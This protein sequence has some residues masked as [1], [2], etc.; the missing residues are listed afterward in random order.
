MRKLT[1][2][3]TL[4]LLPFMISSCSDNQVADIQSGTVLINAS[5]IVEHLDGDCSAVQIRTKSLGNADFSAYTLIK[6]ELDGMSDADLASI[7][8]FFYE[9]G[10]QRNLLELTSRDEINSTRLSEI[11]SPSSDREIFARVTLKSSVCTGQIYYLTL[12]DV[13]ITGIR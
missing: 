11:A 7:Q 12:R 5:G 8:I 13:K 3:T 9:N 6:I 2:I 10:E 4:L 1:V